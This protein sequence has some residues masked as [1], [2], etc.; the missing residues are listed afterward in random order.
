MKWRLIEAISELSVYAV[1]FLYK[2][3]SLIQLISIG[4][5]QIKIGAIQMHRRFGLI[6]YDIKLGA[7][8]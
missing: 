7:L 6:K 3:D 1:S 5:F 4:R 2:K 8:C